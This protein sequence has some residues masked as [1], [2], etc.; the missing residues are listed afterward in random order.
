MPVDRGVL[1]TG[2]RHTSGRGSRPQL[3]TSGSGAERLRTQKERRPQLAAGALAAGVLVACVPAEDEDESVEPEDSC[4][5][6]EDS[7]FE[8]FDD[9]ETVLELLARE[10]VA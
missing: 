1:C 10:S 4:E 7:V 2:E 6:L 9:D 5:E 3:H 8:A